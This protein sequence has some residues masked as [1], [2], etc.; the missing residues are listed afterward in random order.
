MYRGKITFLTLVK[1]GAMVGLVVALVALSGCSCKKQE[2][3]I[4]Q[5]DSQIADLQQQLSEKDA[6]NAECEE[7]ASE[8][9]VN[10]QAQKA[11][12]AVLVEQMNEVVYISVRDEILF[13]SSQTMVLDTMESTLEVIA[14]TVS[15]HPDWD[16]MV[17]GHTDNRKIMEEFQVQWP[18]NWELG[19]FRS[20]A[21]VRYM[22]HKFNLPADRFAVMSY[23]PFHPV[24][25]ND[26][27]E[28]RAQ[29]RRVTFILHT[30]EEMR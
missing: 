25:S 27:D 7:I 29:N 18:S 12:N 13:G 19:A 2:E 17:A 23:G 26:S 5:L 30:P 6:T 1:L 24:V 14:N 15:Q 8:L 28:G 20:A 11:E 3:Q 21:V 4:A 10:L 16:I 22:T 9:R